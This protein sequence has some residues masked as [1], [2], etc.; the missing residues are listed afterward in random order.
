MS[1]DAEVIQEHET[2]ASAA[3]AQHLSSHLR[4]IGHDVDQ[5]RRVDGI[6]HLICKREGACIHAAQ[7]DMVQ[8]PS[9]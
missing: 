4:G 8:V 9:Q 5:I 6:E 3:D 1:V 7:R 2:S